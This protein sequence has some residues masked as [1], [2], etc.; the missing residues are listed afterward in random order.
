MEDKCSDVLK[1][2]FELANLQ[3]DL[4]D[5]E[6]A[7]SLSGPLLKFAELVKKCS[8]AASVELYG[9]RVWQ[10]AMML[11]QNPDDASE[12]LKYLEEV[13]KVFT[14]ALKQINA[15]NPKIVADCSCN[16][17]VTLTEKVSKAKDDTR[18]FV[19]TFE[20]EKRSIQAKEIASL[21]VLNLIAG[22]QLEPKR[23]GIC[24]KQDCR[25]YFYKA[26]STKRNIC[27]ECASR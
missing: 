25:K 17:S 4:I 19:Y 13:H 27:T 24:Q 26:L 22:C 10:H 23:F 20:S 12:A 14:H 15:K 5:K 1:G 16:I 18:P 2:F 9:D 21:V 6:S 11:L 8:E 3:L 7:S